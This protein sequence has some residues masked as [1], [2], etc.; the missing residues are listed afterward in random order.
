MT[1]KK[2]NQDVP[3]RGIGFFQQLIEQLRLSWALLLDNRVPVVLKLIPIAAVAYVISPIDLIPD[4]FIGLGQLDDLGVLM[5]AVT[6]FNN[7]APG[8]VVAEHIARLRSGNTY[9]ISRDE[10]GTVIDVKS[11]R[12]ED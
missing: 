12:T 8:D 10:E 11:H 6:T 7:L 4:F 5:I 9:R 2:K 3:Q 1:E